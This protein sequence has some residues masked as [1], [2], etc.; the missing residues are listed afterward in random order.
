MLNDFFMA[1]VRLSFLYYALATGNMVI[2]YTFL[3]FYQGH[4][5]IG[6]DGSTEDVCFSMVPDPTFTFV[7]APCCPTFYFV[8][9]FWGGG[10]GYIVNLPID[11]QKIPIYISFVTKVVIG[12]NIV[13]HTMQQCVVVGMKTY[14][15]C[16]CLKFNHKPHMDLASKNK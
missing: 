1:F 15:H 4:A 14:K 12:H 11:V 2:L 13:W 10:G 16:F 3:C 5:H 9:V 7:R 8:R 6:Y